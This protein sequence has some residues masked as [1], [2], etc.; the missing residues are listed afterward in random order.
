MEF[1]KYSLLSGVKT[2]YKL[3]FI[4]NSKSSQE[5]VDFVCCRLKEKVGNGIPTQQDLTQICESVCVFFCLPFFMSSVS[6][7]VHY[8]GC[9]VLPIVQYKPN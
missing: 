2:N 4:R 5:V 1:G 3:F 6:N 7:V 9:R 8:L